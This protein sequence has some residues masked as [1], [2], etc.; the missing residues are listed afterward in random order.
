MLKTMKRV[1]GV[2]LV[3]AL[4][5]VMLLGTGCTK[6]ATQEQLDQLDALRDEALRAESKVDEL[7]KEKSS[8]EQQIASKEAELK[9]AQQEKEKVAQRLKER[10]AKKAAEVQAEGGAQ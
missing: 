6:M 1:T 3:S 10:K 4:F 7:R 5:L 8:L 9:A 2:G